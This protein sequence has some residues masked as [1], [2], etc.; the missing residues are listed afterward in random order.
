[1]CVARTCDFIISLDLL[2]TLKQRIDLPVKQS[3]V[4]LS[5]RSE[6]E[7]NK[8]DI[9]IISFHPSLIAKWNTHYQGTKKDGFNK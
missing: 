6:S 9:L 8:L 3:G 7:Y 5:V 4:A 1:M 2:I